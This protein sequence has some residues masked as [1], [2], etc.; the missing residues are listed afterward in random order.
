MDRR[1]GDCIVAESEP[2]SHRIRR[3]SRSGDV[4]TVVAGKDIIV[5][6]GGLATDRGGN[7]LVTECYGWRV[8]RIDTADNNRVTTLAGPVSGP[9]GFAD[10]YG[11]LLVS[12]CCLRAR[13]TS[14]VLGRSESCSMWVVLV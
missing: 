1:T 8:V 9:T 3:V 14:T 11:Y 6:P 12:F 7:I 4:S 2:N 13:D 5:E 10:G